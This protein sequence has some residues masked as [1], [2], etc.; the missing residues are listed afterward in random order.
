[1]IHKCQVFMSIRSCVRS[2]WLSRAP[3]AACPT[4]T[5]GPISEHP[6]LTLIKVKNCKK[7]LMLL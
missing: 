4:G 6:L 2:S 1:M 5:S 3:H 7:H